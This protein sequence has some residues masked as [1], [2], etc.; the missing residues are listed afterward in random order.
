VTLLDALV[1]ARS[2]YHHSMNHRSVVLP[3]TVV[4]V[5]DEPRRGGQST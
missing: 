5:R 4:E 3:G 2:A 1:L